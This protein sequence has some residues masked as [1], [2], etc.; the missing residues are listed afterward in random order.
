MHPFLGLNPHEVRTALL[1]GTD[2]PLYSR[3]AEVLKKNL[4]QRRKDAKERRGNIIHNQSPV[5]ERELIPTVGES[6][7]LESGREQL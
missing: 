2:L 3:P 4:T 5:D 1:F 7:S 6:T